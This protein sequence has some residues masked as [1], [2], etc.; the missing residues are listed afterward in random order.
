MKNNIIYFVA[1]F[2]AILSI[3]A[4]FSIN[5]YALS[6]EEHLSNEADEQRARKLFLEVRCLVCQGQVIESSDTEFSFE[7]RKLIRNKITQGKSD[8]EIKEE[9]IAEF[10]EDI[11]TSRRLNKNNILLWILPIIFAILPIFY[12]IRKN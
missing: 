12:L 3:L 1:K 2:T 4:I 6:V 8:Q 5:S 10:G 11:L 7:M 9:L